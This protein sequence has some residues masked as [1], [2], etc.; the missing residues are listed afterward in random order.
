MDSG[1]GPS[2]LIVETST[3]V[4]CSVDSKKR[5]H[6]CGAG[7]LTSARYNDFSVYWLVCSQ[8]LKRYG[9]LAD[10]ADLIVWV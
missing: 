5:K 6:K 2:R 8:S 7:L 10:L 4:K 3:A 1:W 9:L